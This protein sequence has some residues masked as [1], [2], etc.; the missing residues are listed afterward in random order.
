MKQYEENTLTDKKHFRNWLVSLSVDQKENL[1]VNLQ[2]VNIFKVLEFLLIKNGQWTDISENVHRNS[3]RQELEKIAGRLINKQSIKFDMES[4]ADDIII[5]LL[6]GQPEVMEMLWTDMKP[7]QKIA[8]L[9]III[10]E[11]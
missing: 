3:S 5:V 2:K 4:E 1:L 6:Q 8:L 11:E 7:A 9:L 10:E